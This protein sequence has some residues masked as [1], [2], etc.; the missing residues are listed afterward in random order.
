MVPPLVTKNGIEVVGDDFSDS[1]NSA[2][3]RSKTPRTSLSLEF[4]FCS[5]NKF[6]IVYSFFYNEFL[7]LIFYKSIFT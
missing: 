4:W 7:K 3:T 6:L 1:I 5:D 2:L